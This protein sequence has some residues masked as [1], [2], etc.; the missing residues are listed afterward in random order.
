MT[1]PRQIEIDVSLPGQDCPFV[2]PEIV[3]THVRM[4][5]APVI[6]GG[7]RIV[8]DVAA[9]V[10]GMVMMADRSDIRINGRSFDAREA[11]HAGE[12]LSRRGFWSLKLPVDVVRGR[13]GEWERRVII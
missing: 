8:T 6:V 3:R 4:Q 13:C 7:S 12:L 5:V 1:F 2:T 11:G 9:F 10:G